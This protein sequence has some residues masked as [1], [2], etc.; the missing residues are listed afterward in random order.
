MSCLF[1]REVSTILVMHREFQ[2]NP[3]K[4]VEEENF[5]YLE[6]ESRRSGGSGVQGTSGFLMRVL[7]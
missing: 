2:N 1:Y 4:Q 5:M 7:Y 3:N 6:L